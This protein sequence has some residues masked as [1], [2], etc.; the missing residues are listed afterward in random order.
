MIDLLD[1]N[2]RL[3][4]GGLCVNAGV[5]GFGDIDWPLIKTGVAS[6]GVCMPGIASTVFGEM[7]D[8]R[9]EPLPS[10]LTCC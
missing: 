7:G 5:V 8:L 9:T 10:W 6:I 3:S 1:G 4:S 2:A